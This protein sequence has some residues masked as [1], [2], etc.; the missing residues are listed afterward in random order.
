MQNPNDAYLY[1]QSKIK[2]CYEESFKLTKLSRKRSKDKKWITSGIKTSSKQKNRLYRKW[3]VTH[4][5]ED[6]IKYTNYRKIFKQVSA[7]AQNAF[8]KNILI[9]KPTALNSCGL[10]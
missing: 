4:K 5:K 3:L 2:K 10:T 7:K 9:P 6:E 8:F 1:F